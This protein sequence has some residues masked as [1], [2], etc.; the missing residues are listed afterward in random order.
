[1]PVAAVINNTPV[2]TEALSHCCSLV[3]SANVSLFSET[4]YSW[5]KLSKSHPGG[6]LIPISQLSLTD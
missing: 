4:F 3:K 6:V 1:V 2:F 5:V